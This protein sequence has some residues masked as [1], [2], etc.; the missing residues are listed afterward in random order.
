MTRTTG[1]RSAPR[2]PALGLA[3]LAA[4]S[5]SACTNL[6]AVRTFAT[7]SAAAVENR[8]VLSDY[9]QAPVVLARLAPADRSAALTAEA[10]ERAKQRS[11]LWSVQ[12]ILGHY[13]RTLGDLAASSLPS[14]N[15]EIGALA[16]ALEGAK[17]AVGASAV[18]NETIEAAGSIAKVLTRLSLDGWRQAR[19][20]E[21][22]R[23]VDPSVQKVVAG[24]G[25]VVRK[26]FAAS[27]DQEAEAI[28]SY[29]ETALA[30]ARS[31]GEEEA[32]G[33]LARYLEA[34]ALD[35]VEARRLRLAPYAEALAKV[36]KG[37]A[38]LAANAGTLDGKTLVEKLKQLSKELTT[39]VNAAGTL[40]G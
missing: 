37:H 23:E 27:L 1:T 30:D 40:E 29:F 35:G 38:E 26:D 28:R 10:K 8:E 20:A 34:Q 4:V 36:G 15:P 39:L 6:D 17:G 19:I 3:G 13:F 12:R 7:T 25:E 33:R 18:T 2:L 11:R 22:V 24:L 5:L 21:I 31:R 16:T 9:A 32:A 14:A